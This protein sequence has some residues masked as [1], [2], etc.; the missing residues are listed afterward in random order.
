MTFEDKP[1]LSIVGCKASTDFVNIY[2]S[3][4]TSTTT[5]TTTSST[6]VSLPIS[7]STTP[8]TPPIS[9]PTTTTTST[10]TTTPAP[11]DS[12][13][14]GAIVGGALGGVAI[15]SLAAAL[16]V[17]LVLRHRRHT[18]N[19][20]EPPMQQP[21]STETPQSPSACGYPDPVHHP[22]HL[23]F[24]SWGGITAGLTSDVSSPGG[25]NYKF[26]QP[27][28]VA[29]LGG[30]D[31]LIGGGQQD[32]PH[33]QPGLYTSELPAADVEERPGHGQN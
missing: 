26:Q 18:A 29:G 16:I 14:I 10:P 2:A 32:L 4:T 15:V 8:P 6:S 1:I 21:Y 30:G 11:S 20:A 31:Q 9:S 13:P 12:P 19:P 22:G 33:Y 28:T 25:D 27:V 17:W 5:D 23:S 3:P 7:S 24:G